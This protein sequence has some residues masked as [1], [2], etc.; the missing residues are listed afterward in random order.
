MKGSNAAFRKDLLRVLEIFLWITAACLV[1]VLPW[2]V[3]GLHPV[4]G[5]S[6]AFG[7]NNKAGILGLGI[8]L[9]I[10]TMLKAWVFNP[11][12]VRPLNWLRDKVEFIPSFH[13]ARSEYL[14]LAACSAAMFFA[15]LW[16]NS[17][18]VMPY[19]GGENAYFLGR[20]DLLSIGYKP[21]QDFQFNYG[22][23]LLYVPLWLSRAT[24][25][26]LGFED[27]Y[28]WCVALSFVIGFG[29]VFVFLRAMSI[30]DRLRPLI[31]LLSL[32]MWMCITMGLNYSPLRF[33]VLPAALVLFDRS[34]SLPSVGI[35]KWLITGISAFL[36]S[37]AC[38]LISPEMGIAISLGLLAYASIAIFSDRTPSGLAILVAI[39]LCCGGMSICFRG[40]LHGVLSFSSGANNFPVY[41]NVTNLMLLGSSLVVIPG[42]LSAAWI[43]KADRRASLAAAISLAALPLLAA[44]YG[45][46]DP[47]HVVINGLMILVMM[48]AVASSI[49]KPALYGWTAFFAIVVVLMGQISYW[50]GYRA[51]FIQAFEIRDSYSKNPELVQKWQDAWS[52]QR[53]WSPRSSWLDWR[54][55]VPYPAGFDDLVKDKKVGIPFGAD[56]GIERSLKLQKNFGIIYNESPIPEW[57]TPKDI[58]RSA[59]ECLAYDFLLVPDSIIQQAYSNIDIPAYQRST[60]E[61]LSG[62]LLYPVDSSVR[63]A[64][65]I[66]E[67]E[68]IRA[69]I[70]SCEPIGNIPG[71]V[72]LRPVNPVHGKNR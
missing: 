20:I 26:H 72:L 31:L 29:C 37:A 22:P 44:S 62:L 6:Y 48:F 1:F 3:G 65:Y 23:A 18:L 24:F 42:L 40:Y 35:P 55:T 4:K 50:N 63:N 60:S 70:A 47:G 66:P 33:T 16:W 64:P 45:R 14:I 10:L 12:C 25:G 15:N 17:V 19:W 68:L 36:S 59:K 46:C 56:I 51:L 5:E 57:Y 8:C 32:V 52:F 9:A 53:S 2:H 30:P 7:F 38:F 61:F 27:A 13:Q 54:K 58:E 11:P 67:L 69:L 21:Y 43:G 49:G 39:T 41:P 28:A 71:Y 34:L